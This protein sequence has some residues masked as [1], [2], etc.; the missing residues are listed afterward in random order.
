M[1]RLIPIAVIA[2]FLIIALMQ[3]DRESL[4]CSISQIPLWLALSLFTI[5]IISQLLVNAQWH[6]IAKTSDISMSFRDMLYVNCQGAI[7]DAITPGVKIGGEIT[8]AVQLSRKTGCKGEQAA[9]VVAVQKLFSISALCAALLL[10]AGW[11]LALPF[12]VLLVSIFFVPHRIKL[13]I[14]SR[15]E[16]RHV[17][18]RKLRGFFIAALDQIMSIRDNKKAWSMLLPLSLLI[19]LL[20]PAKMYLL[21]IQFYPDAQILQIATIAFAAYM[22]AMLP[23][24][25]GG[26]GGFEA[27]M[28]GLLVA[29]GMA[30]SNAA[31][32]TIFLRFLTFWFVML[33]SLIFVTIYKLLAK[34]RARE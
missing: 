14:Q 26:L 25:P 30:V 22:V 10:I 23:I 6:K 12:L 9:A 17:W 34:R 15:K 13:Y 16:P 11:L 19:W 5:Q 29:L 3:I 33:T 1:K 27:T 28:T 4:L 20:Y 32:I 8:R 2:T 21:V 31:V 7:M 18:S 24:F